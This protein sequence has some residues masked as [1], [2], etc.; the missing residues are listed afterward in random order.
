[1]KK[2]LFCAATIGCVAGLIAYMNKNG[3]PILGNL[4]MKLPVKT[5]I[6]PYDLLLKGMHF[7]ESKNI[8]I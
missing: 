6:D 4:T 8:V 5:G 1:M 7:A 2:H 3:L